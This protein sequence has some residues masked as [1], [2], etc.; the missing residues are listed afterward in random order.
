MQRSTQDVEPY[1]AEPAPFRPPKQRSRFGRLLR[2]LWFQVV[3]G[4]V[5]GIAVGLLLPSVGKQL[6]P[7]SDWFIALVKMIVI[8]VVFCVGSLG[9]ASMDSLRKAGWP[10]S[11][12]TAPKACS[13]SATSSCCSPALAS[14]TS[15]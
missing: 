3:L 5:L 15:W 12:I 7:L 10:P 11:P 1:H 2:E 14:S 8:P 6:T 4:A 13:N 9:I